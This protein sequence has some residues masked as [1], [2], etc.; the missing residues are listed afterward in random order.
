MEA[1]I[2]GK[3]KESVAVKWDKI[4]INIKDL[5]KK[6]LYNRRTGRKSRKKNKTCIT[7][8]Q[9]QKSLEL[10]SVKRIYGYNG[11]TDTRRRKI[12]PVN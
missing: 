12:K 7:G 6:D 8:V 3:K 9:I 1:I 2:Y 10:G 4:C 11:Y 5:K